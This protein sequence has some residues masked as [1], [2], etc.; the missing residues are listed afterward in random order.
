MLTKIKENPVTTLSIVGFI[1]F[2]VAIGITSWPLLLGLFLTGLSVV[3]IFLLLYGIDEEA[4]RRENKR[5]Q[6]ARS[7]VIDEL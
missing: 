5:L 7:K 2:I 3:I 1:S 4:K 6:K